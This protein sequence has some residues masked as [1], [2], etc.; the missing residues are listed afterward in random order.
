MIDIKTLILALP[1]GWSGSI[2][3]AAGI[4]PFK[5]SVQPGSE[6]W[7]FGKKSGPQLGT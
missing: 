1:P 4:F 3:P 2:K 6:F 7:H 5:L